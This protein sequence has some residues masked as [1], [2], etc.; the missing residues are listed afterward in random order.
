[1]AGNRQ[2]T[3]VLVAG[4]HRSGTSA[5]AHALGLAGCDLPK[6][7]MKHRLGT[8]ERSIRG[9]SESWSITRLNMEF[10]SSAKHQGFECID[11]AIDASEL[12]QQFHDRAVKM[13]HDEFADSHLFVMKDPRL[14]LLLKFWVN[15][16]TEFGARP[17]VICPIRNP[18][19]VA[20][21]LKSRTASDLRTL[22]YLTF[23]WL[24][25]VLDAEVNSRSI[26]RTFTRYS[27]LLEDP[28]TLLDK[29]A[30]ALDVSLPR[31]SMLWRRRTIS[32]HPSPLHIV[33][34]VSR[35][36]PYALILDV[37]GRPGRFTRFLI[38]GWILRNIPQIQQN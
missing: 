33:T 13:L 11:H 18:L 27:D 29:A 19:E 17:V 22:N 7:L 28:L 4:M 31:I 24:R 15:A 34:I 20:Y 10:L 21:S 25:Y 9:H 5:L 32:A 38:V 16:V 6:T 2:K 26:P 23:L 14:C 3:A 36:R 8:G 35:K 12:T 30:V 37:R 1:M